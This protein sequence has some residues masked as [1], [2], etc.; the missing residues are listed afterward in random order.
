MDATTWK[1]DREQLLDELSCWI[2]ELN[3]SG[4]VCERRVHDAAQFAAVAAYRSGA[5]LQDAIAAGKAIVTHHLGSRC[6]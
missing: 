3:L 1:A 5:A 6:S 4:F 2:L